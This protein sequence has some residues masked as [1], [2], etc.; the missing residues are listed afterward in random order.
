MEL[1]YYLDSKGKCP[2]KLWLNEVDIALRARILARLA[3]V[4]TGN[5]GDSRPVGLGV[6]ELRFFYGG[7]LRVYFGINHHGTVVLLGGVKASQSRDI[8]QAQSFWLDYLE[9]VNE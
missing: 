4:A 8:Y 3:R 9:R 1:Q 5:F 2:F 6:Y 7:G